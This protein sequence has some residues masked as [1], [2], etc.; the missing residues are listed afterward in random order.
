[1]ALQSGKNIT[2][3]RRVDDRGNVLEED[4]ILEL[5]LNKY[6]KG[7]HSSYQNYLLLIISVKYNLLPLYVLLLYFYHFAMPY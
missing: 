7:A 4:G 1:M 2:E 5:D 3:E 6:D